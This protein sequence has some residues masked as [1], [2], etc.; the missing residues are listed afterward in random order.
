M[1]QRK[2][3]AWDGNADTLQRCG[4][5]LWNEVIGYA[6]NRMVAGRTDCRSG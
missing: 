4:F 2:M 5:R 1:R 3:K 6:L